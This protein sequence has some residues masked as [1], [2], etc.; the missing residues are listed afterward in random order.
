MEVFGSVAVPVL[1]WEDLLE[2]PRGGA[3]VLRRRFLD[4]GFEAREAL[5]ECFVDL[6]IELRISLARFDQAGLG[7]AESGGGAIEPHSGLHQSAQLIRHNGRYP[8]GPGLLHFKGRRWVRAVCSP[9]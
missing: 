7:D 6:F 5:L 3:P 8:F 1:L 4:G 9:R 2:D